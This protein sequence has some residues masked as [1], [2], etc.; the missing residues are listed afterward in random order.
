MEKK[1]TLNIMKFLCKL[2]K[3]SAVG[4]FWADD[5]LLYKIY[6][7]IA[8][9]TYIS[10]NSLEWIEIKYNAYPT[11]IH[12]DVTSYAVGQLIVMIRLAIIKYKRAEV[13]ELIYKMIETCK[14]E[15][16]DQVLSKRYNK[17]KN[18]VW[19]QFITVM[20]TMV[21]FSIEAIRRTYADG[22]CNVLYLL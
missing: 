3:Y 1:S 10:V 22:G 5:Y 9:S 16:T 19:L 6:T 14:N 18:C 2:L 13:K 17:F 4:E 12:N 8:F 7:I 20:I 21:S 15:E 11:D